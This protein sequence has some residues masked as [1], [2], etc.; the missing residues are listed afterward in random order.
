MSLLGSRR[1][2][3]AD[4][5]ADF[6]NAHTYADAVILNKD[7]NEIS[8]SVNGV[9]TLVYTISG[10]V[11]E[12][13]TVD[14]INVNDRLNGSRIE[15]TV[16]STAGTVDLNLPVQ[17]TAG[18][19]FSI[20]Q[21]A[22]V[23]SYLFVA[24]GAVAGQINVGANLAAAQANVEGAI[25]GTDGFNAPSNWCTAAPF[26]ADVSTFTHLN[27]GF[28]EG[29]ITQITQTWTDGSNTFSATNFA[30][31][32]SDPQ[33]INIGES[34]MRL[35]GNGGLRIGSTAVISA[36]G[37]FNSHPLDPGA[38]GL[39]IEAEFID[40]TQ[41]GA[42]MHFHNLPGVLD[43]SF[44]V[45]DQASLNID[46]TPSASKFVIGAKDTSGDIVGLNVPLFPAHHL[47][48]RNLA[49]PADADLVAGDL[50][51][52]FDDNNITPA[53]K[54]KAKQADGTVVTGT[55]LLT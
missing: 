9:W 35:S 25:N 6:P 49:A 7:T 10:S 33:Q 28:V 11:P 18:D 16:G 19:T 53:L 46:L 3:V 8:V 15:L 32:A 34:G 51:F 26:A 44:Q 13:L 37:S 12:P 20:G 21:P 2:F 31:N 39:F 1:F 14:V 41:G 55:V 50:A 36:L 43:P 38:D 24:A 42:L 23:E 4:T 27:V 17:P 54:I 22:L 29:V 45:A 48:T 47:G 5:V 52:W 30:S 40:N